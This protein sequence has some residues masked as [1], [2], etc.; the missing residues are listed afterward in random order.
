MKLNYI[1]LHTCIH[2][3]IESHQNAILTYSNIC[4][5]PLET[6]ILHTMKFTSNERKA[7]V[8]VLELLL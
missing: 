7:F 1:Y 4:I 6:P 5:F 2:T 3:M 8:G